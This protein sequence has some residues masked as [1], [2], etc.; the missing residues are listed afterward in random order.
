[1]VTVISGPNSADVATGR[2]VRELRADFAT[3]FNVPD[4]ATAVL[5]GREVT[6]DTTPQDGDR[7]V[8]T[9]PSGEKG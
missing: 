5:N 4:R 2:T 6:D 3:A 9:V 7:L 1:M 8:F